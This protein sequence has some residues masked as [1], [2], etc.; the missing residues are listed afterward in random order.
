[1]I[2]PVIIQ[3]GYCFIWVNDHPQPIDPITVTITPYTK[4]LTNL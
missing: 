4:Y 2:V 1:M 3:Y